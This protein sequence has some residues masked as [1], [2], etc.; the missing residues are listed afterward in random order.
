VAAGAGDDGCSGVAAVQQT[1]A[2]IDLSD[3]VEI[4]RACAVAADG[5]EAENHP[6]DVVF[7]DERLRGGNSDTLFQFTRM[8][9]GRVP[10]AVPVHVFCG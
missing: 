4:A 2:G 8:A 1:W 5:E 7:A 3:S 9:L 6:L 10:W